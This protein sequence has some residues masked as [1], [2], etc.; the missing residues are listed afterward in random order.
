M[1][2]LETLKHFARE[3]IKATW[4]GCDVEGNMIQDFAVKLKLLDET[5]Y[6]PEIHGVADYDAMPGDPWYTFS[7]MIKE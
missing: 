2:D 1:T 7:D 4:E 6:N 3:I 5:S